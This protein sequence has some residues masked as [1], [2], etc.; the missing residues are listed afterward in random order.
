MGV[1]IICYPTGRYGFAGRVPVS[2]AFDS[3][4]EGDLDVAAHSGPGFARRIAER[5]GRTFDSLSWATEAEAR[6]YA[7]SLGFAV[8]GD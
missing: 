2:L 1:H 8:T 5:N 7:A 6:A 4:H 3:T